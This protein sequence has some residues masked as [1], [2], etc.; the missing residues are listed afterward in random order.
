MYLLWVYWLLVSLCPWKEQPVQ[1]DTKYWTAA[2][3]N[4]NNWWDLAGKGSETWLNLVAGMWMGINHWEPDGVGLKKTFQL[5]SIREC[6]ADRRDQPSYVVSMTWCREN[7]VCSRND[8]WTVSRRHSTAS[9]WHSVNR[10]TA[11]R[12]TVRAAHDD[13]PRLSVWQY[14]LRSCY[15]SRKCQNSTGSSS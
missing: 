1:W 11:R 12:R 5:I 15:S 7:A 2:G 13:N 4:G 9:S 3:G 14:Y 8:C 10:R 6:G